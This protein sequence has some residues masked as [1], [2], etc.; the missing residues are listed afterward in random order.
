MFYVEWMA[1]FSGLAGA[2]LIA[3]NNRYSK[4]GFVAFLASNFLW[5]YFGYA[6]Q[7]W[8]MVV[9]QVGFTMTSVTGIWRWFKPRRI[10]D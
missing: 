5:L 4:W 2:A 10:E 6:N 3:L 8:G 7:T 1:S 9:M